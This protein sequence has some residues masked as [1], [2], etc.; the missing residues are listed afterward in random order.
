MR[1]AA[2][3]IIAALA[4]T[5]CSSSGPADEDAPLHR[6][7]KSLVAAVE[8]S[9]AEKGA[10]RFTIAPPATG[11]GVRYPSNGTVRLGGEV[12]GMDATTTRPVRS[13]GDAVELRLV[14]T[15]KDAAF[16]KLPAALFGL[17][18]EKPWVRLDRRVDD[19]FTTT[20]LGF[21]DVVF[22]Q[23]AFTTY[24]LPVIKAGGEL[25]L[26]A[27]VGGNT[28]YSIAVDYRKA[29]DALT[30]EG[31]RTELELALDQQVAGSTGEIELDGA[32]LPVRIAF[33]TQFQ[34]ARIVDEARFSDWGT[35]AEITAPG[36]AEISPRS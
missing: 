15:A 27:Q 24:H 6:D 17:P 8:K 4:L 1:L 20:L 19:D 10:Y 36:P 33:Y 14:S 22:Q 9:V 5:A 7:V 25:E 35:G 16:V 30:D 3:A 11:G 18:A 31:L 2:T 23:A 26:T 12:P 21:H 13:G 29:H 28:R 32:G 34:G